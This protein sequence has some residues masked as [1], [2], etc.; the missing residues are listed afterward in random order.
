MAWPYR[1]HKVTELIES[2]L[3]SDQVT[4]DSEI[5]VPLCTL[6]GHAFLHT[7]SPNPR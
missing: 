2:G 6:C 3:L 7:L 4:F 1:G 5:F